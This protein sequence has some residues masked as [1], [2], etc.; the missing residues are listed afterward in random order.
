MPRHPRL[1]FPGV[2]L[3]IVQRGNNRLPCFF[4]RTDYLVF[5]DLLVHAAA[6]TRCAVHAYVLMRN[7]VHLLASPATAHGASALM[8]ALGQNYVQ[9]INRRY[10]RHGTLW[11]GR[12]RSCLVQDERYLMV[13]QRYIELNPVRACLVDDP[14]LYEWSSY[15]ANA[16]GER[17]ALVTPHAL[18]TSLADDPP[19]REDA[20]RALFDECITSDTAECVRDAT[21]SDF[22]LGDQDFIDEMAT[23]LGRSVT[24]RAP[25]RPARARSMSRRKNSA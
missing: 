5:L 13:C 3:H 17:N 15:R 12:F 19:G 9:Y 18:Y 22:A 2:P 20:Y 6:R 4:E 14:A 21:N 25:G 16:C 24:P 10:Q 11:Q 1:M 8:K 7:H 23:Q